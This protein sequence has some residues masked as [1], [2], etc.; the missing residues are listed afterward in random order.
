[1]LFIYFVCEL[2]K[3]NE[4]YR[5]VI[6]IISLVRKQFFIVEKKVTDKKVI[7]WLKYRLRISTP[8][9]TTT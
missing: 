8:S 7:P 9:S 1:M 5:T 2:L 4:F 6:N 3:S